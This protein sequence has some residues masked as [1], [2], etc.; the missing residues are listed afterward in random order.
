MTLTG[1][2]SKPKLVGGTTKHSNKKCLNSSMRRFFFG[3]LHVV[4]S[5]LHYLNSSLRN[6]HNARISSKFVY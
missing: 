6:G 5:I 2:T 4:L 1:E 3:S